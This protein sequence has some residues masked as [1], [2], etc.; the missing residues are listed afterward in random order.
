MG[1]PPWDELLIDRE[2]QSSS[3]ANVYKTLKGRPNLLVGNLNHTFDNFW[4][5]TEYVPPGCSGESIIRDFMTWDDCVPLSEISLLWNAKGVTPTQKGFYWCLDARAADFGEQID[6]EID[7]ES[8][9]IPINASHDRHVHVLSFF[10]G[11]F[12]GWTYG[13]KHLSAFHGVPAQVVA[14]ESDLL[15]CANYAAN[16]DV[17]IINGYLPV[18]ETLMNHMPKGCVIHG[19]VLS[20]QW[21]QAMAKWHPNILTIS[22]PCQPW[23]GAGNSKG[24]A[25]IDGMCFP[26]AI[27]QAR[28]LQPETIGIEQVTGFNTHDHRALVMKTISM[29][30]YAVKWSKNIDFS[31]CGPVS[32]SR[33]IAIL[34]RVCDIP[35]LMRFL[36]VFFRVMRGFLMRSQ[37]NV[38]TFQTAK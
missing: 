36:R 33:W 20:N 5:A 25:T 19:N 2:I 11:G 31:F 12:G 24:L 4:K 38:K 16:H 14:I 37:G 10:G 28:F 21:M 26:E 35:L 34:Q 29:I 22:P 17:P 30:G 32:R 27:L 3:G 6:F 7:G 9:A 13:M 1:F 18:S 8:T 23:S 15:A